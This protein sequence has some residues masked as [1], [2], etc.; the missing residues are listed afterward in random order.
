MRSHTIPLHYAIGLLV[1][2]FILGSVFSFGL[3]YWNDTT[4]RE[5]CRLVETKFLSY[6]TINHARKPMHI[7]EIAIDCINRE[8]YFIDG[9]SVNPELLQTL[10]E[11]SEQEKITLLI[12]PN[13]NT[14]VEFSYEGGNI[15]S[16]N[17]TITKLNAEASGFLFLGFFMYLCSLLGLYHTILHIIKHK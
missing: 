10:S 17:E 8:R 5:S 3:K 9:V 14:I 13:S 15:L 16:F 2:G 6:D 11:L 12:H 1:V 4:P 7:T